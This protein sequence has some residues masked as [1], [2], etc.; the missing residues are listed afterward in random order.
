M[1]EKL[2]DLAL[3][4]AVQVI[5]DKLVNSVGKTLWSLFWDFKEN[6]DKLQ[7]TWSMVEAVLE[8]AEE[9][10]STKPAVKI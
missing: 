6:V 5:I 10:Q 2:A 9:Q 3:S 7:R 8:D 1:K 4:S